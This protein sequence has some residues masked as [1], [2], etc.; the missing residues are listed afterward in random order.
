MFHLRRDDRSRGGP[1]VVVLHLRVRFFASLFVAVIIS[2]FRNATN[3]YK[4][5]SNASSLR[6]KRKARWKRLSLSLARSVSLSSFDFIP[7]LLKHARI[8]GFT[9]SEVKII[10]KKTK[11]FPHNKK[12]T[13]TKREQRR[14]RRRGH[15]DARRRR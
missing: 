14:R 3:K 8:R 5:A 7:R 1:V 4:T 6:S 10:H 13:Q 11:T 12:I 9:Y 2:H 15:E